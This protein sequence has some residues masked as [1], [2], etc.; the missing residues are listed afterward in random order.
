[1]K[2]PNQI[3]FRICL[4]SKTNKETTMKKLFFAGLFLLASA[5]Q[6]EMLT[7]KKTKCSLFGNLKVKVSGLESYGR[8]GTGYLKANLPMRADCDAVATRF[9]QTM[10]RNATLASVDYDRY[11]DRRTVHRGGNDDKI[12]KRDTMC[13]VYEVK[14]IFVVFSRFGSQTFKNTT[15]R[16]VDTYYGHCR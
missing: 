12:A 14:K 16:L 6:A 5:A 4:L 15:R 9:T 1:M 3:T 8:V 2:G 7:V 11:M 13:E 10:G